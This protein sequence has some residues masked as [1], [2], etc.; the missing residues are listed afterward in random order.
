MIFPTYPGKIPHS[1]PNPHK[2][3]TI[4]YELLVKGPGYLPGGSVG[5]ILDTSNYRVVKGGGS[6][7]RG[8]PNLP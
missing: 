2:E 8:F 3:K 7:G 4:L 5:E 6:K 1:S